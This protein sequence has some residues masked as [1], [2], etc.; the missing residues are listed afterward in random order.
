MTR[1]QCLALAAERDE[2]CRQNRSSVERFRQA[3]KEEAARMLEER[4]EQR[5]REAEEWRSK[6]MMAEE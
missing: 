1:S 5:A 4:I 6:A 3:G 2:W